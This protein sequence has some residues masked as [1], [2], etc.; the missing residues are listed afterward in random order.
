[1]ARSRTHVTSLVSILFCFEKNCFR[2]GESLSDSPSSSSEE[3]EEEASESSLEED[4][5]SSS[6]SDSE[7][8][9]RG[10][11]PLGLPNRSET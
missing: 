9:F 8:S 3:S 6:E 10:L 5:S 11:F 1:M 2:A 4:P 7:E